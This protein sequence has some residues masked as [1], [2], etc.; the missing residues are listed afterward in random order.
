MRSFNSVIVVT[1][2][3][4]LLRC[5]PGEI[6][7]EL[8]RRKG[9]FLNDQA[10]ELPITGE[11]TTAWTALV[12]RVAVELGEPAENEAYRDHYELAWDHPRIR[13]WFHNDNASISVPYWHSG[14]D[15][16]EALRRAF[17]LGRLLQELMGFEARDDQTGLGLGESSLAAAIQEYGSTHDAAQGAVVAQPT[18]TDDGSE[19]H[20]QPS[21]AQPPACRDASGIA[22]YRV[23]HGLRELTD[24]AAVL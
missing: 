14:E 19:Q 5:P 16:A 15:A 11:L 2:D 24:H 7:R 23:L 8:E 3:I 17:L 4:T 13:L 20:P 21:V 10:P 22:G 12:P 6:G 18:P 9:L 1:Y